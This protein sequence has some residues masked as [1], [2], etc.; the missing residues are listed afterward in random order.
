[1]KEF[2][3]LS[4]A[5]SS[6]NHFSVRFGRKGPRNDEKKFRPSNRIEDENENEKAS[7][8]PEPIVSL[9]KLLRFGQRKLPVNGECA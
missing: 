5:F 4:L 2:L 8:G 1:M 6:S 9:E 7:F 3:A